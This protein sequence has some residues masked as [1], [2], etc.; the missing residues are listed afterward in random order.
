[1][2]IE[3]ITPPDRIDLDDDHLSASLETPL[4]TDA[5]DLSDEEKLV[6]E[7]DIEN[8]LQTLGMDLTDDSLKATPN[9][10]PK[11][12][13]KKCLVVFIPTDVL[14]SQASITNTSTMRCW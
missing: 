3:K 13:S 8:I 9:A 10:S 1:M 6:A 11:C 4:R 2:K 5:F 7:K 14:L 12:L